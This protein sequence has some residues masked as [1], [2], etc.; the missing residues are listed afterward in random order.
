VQSQRV[1]DE[2]VEKEMKDMSNGIK[3]DEREK[4]EALQGDDR[5]LL[6]HSFKV[7]EAWEQFVHRHHPP[8]SAD[9]QGADGKK[10]AR[11]LTE[12]E[13]KEQAEAEG[14]FKRRC[15]PALCPV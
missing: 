3:P 1:L 10:P 15:L 14:Y 13:Q 7:R 5:L 12:T 11:K 8:K 6:L 9:K 2:R 4:L